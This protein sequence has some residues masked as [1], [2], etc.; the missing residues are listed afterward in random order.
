EKFAE[1]KK[2]T[3][4]AIYLY[5]QL[6]M[7]TAVA[8]AQFDL[9]RLFEF[10]NNTDSALYYASLARSYWLK[11]EAD[12]RVLI[13]NNMEVSLLLK[14][15]QPEKAKTI[16]ATSQMLV[17][18]PDMHWQAVIDFYFTSMLLY[19]SLNDIG[20]AGDYQQRY[21]SKVAALRAAGLQVKS[22]Y[23]NDR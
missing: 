9:A 6:S 5:S 20:T 2:E 18:K 21:L 11:K 8:I 14:R 3:H 23:E 10:E 19:R 7:N 15:Q 4:A 1:A 13:I 12:L 22:Y 16:Q 17:N